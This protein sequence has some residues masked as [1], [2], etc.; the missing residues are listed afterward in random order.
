M[1]EVTVNDAI[2]IPYSID[3]IVEYEDHGTIT[4]SVFNPEDISDTNINGV[5]LQS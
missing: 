5:F 3:M 1:F 4:S 2:D